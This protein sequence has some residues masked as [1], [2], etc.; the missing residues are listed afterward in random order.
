[1]SEP[2]MIALDHARRTYPGFALDVTM[3]VP[4]GAVTALVGTNGSGK[5]TTFRVLLGLARLDGGEARLFGRPSRALDVTTKRRVAAVF[6]DSGF[7]G[8]CTPRDVIAQLSAFYPK[9]DA[10]EC[11]ALLERFA[12]PQ[13]KPLSGFSTGMLAKTK[14]IMAIARRPDLLVLDEPTAGLDVLARDEILD[15]LRGFMETEGRSILISS[16]ISRDVESLCDD[17]YF[18]RDGSIR[19]HETIQRLHDDY[20]VL[21]LTDAQMEAADP[22]YLL[23]RERVAGG[24]HALTDQRGYYRENMPGVETRRGDID[25]LI[26]VM[27]R[28][29]DL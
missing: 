14:T 7:D 29:E 3:R 13:D 16:H 12:L 10:G 4:E 28:G 6:Q 18:I 25:E 5:T 19:M 17:F 9:F 26:A 21:V 2:T 11:R 22:R 20:A 8:T 15:L 27:S 24:W 23:A 1:M